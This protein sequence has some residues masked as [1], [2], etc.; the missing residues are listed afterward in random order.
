MGR[1]VGFVCLLFLA[2]LTTVTGQGLSPST[3]A[4]EYIR[5]NS[6]VIAVEV[7]TYT[8]SY[9]LS[10]TT[11]N[12]PD[13]GGGGTISVSTGAGCAWTAT[14]GADWISIDGGASGQGSGTVSYSVSVNNGI[15]SRNGII[16]IGSQTFTISENGT[17]PS[18]PA[19]QFV[20][21][22]PCRA[23]DTRSGSLLAAGSTRNFTLNGSC[24][25]PSSAQAYSLNL[26]AIP[27]AAAN[28]TVWPAGEP[29]PGTTSLNSD[30]RVKANA[31]IVAAGSGGIVSVNTTGDTNLLIDVNGYFAPA[32]GSTLA[33]YPITPCRIA[34]TR[35]A[36]APYLT[37][38]STR[39]FAIQSICGVPATAQVYSLNLSSLPHGA[40][41]FLN[42]WAA[43][44]PQPPTSTLNAPTGTDTANA[45]I[46]AAGSGGQISVYGPVD[47]HQRLLCA[48]WKRRLIAVCL[49]RAVPGVRFAVAD[50]YSAF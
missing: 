24:G 34:D 16:S 45:A 4:K 40:L 41:T 49:L 18:S 12:F 29:Q 15:S 23:V 48:G 33:F 47:R 39:S 36:N 2:S 22:A 10:P 32:G 42:A 17:G 35:G 20:L 11:H 1:C 5:F 30:G 38:G 13:T 19:L 6:Q 14:P 28:L 37:G 21:V 7:P 27:N 46:V 9:T 44:Q 3:P 50:W 43:G 26:T 31:A 8:C 25:I